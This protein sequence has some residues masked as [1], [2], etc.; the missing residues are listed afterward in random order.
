MN[1]EEISQKSTKVHHGR[2]VKRF[3]EMQGIKQ[4]ALAEALEVN[5]QQI[6]RLESKD[7]IEDILLEK[8]AKELNITI[9][10]IKKC[11]DDIA[12]SII[13]N[14]FHEQSVAYQY[15]F[16]PIEKIIA[17]YDEKIELHERMLKVM[18]D[19]SMLLERLLEEKR[20]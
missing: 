20:Q 8:L 17:L 5:Q 7:I 18:H 9:E 19:K 10:A 16:N 12:V 3:R 11:D 6:S 4:E 13:S 1:S 15:N 2:N 14:T